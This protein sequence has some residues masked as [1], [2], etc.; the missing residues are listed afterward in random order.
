MLWAGLSSGET[1][2]GRRGEWLP[3]PLKVSILVPGR[4]HAFELAR[5]LINLGV[6]VRLVTSYPRGK[7][8]AWG[9]PDERVRS[10]FWHYLLTRLAWEMGGES[11]D[12]PLGRWHSRMFS[13]AASRQA[14]PAD[15]IHA[16]AGSA[17]DSLMRRFPSGRP[18][19][20]DRGS[21]HRIRQDEILGREHRDLGLFWPRRHPAM[22]RRELGEYQRATKITVPS[23]FVFRSFTE[24]GI[25]PGRLHLNGYGVDL[26][27]FVPME[28]QEAERQP[29]R[30]IH[31]GS[32]SVRKG[33]HHLCRGFRKAGLSGAQ[34]LLVGGKTAETDG[35]IGRDRRGIRLVGHLPQA[36]L[37]KEYQ[38]ASLFCLASL[39]EG[40]AMVQL[41]ALACGLPLVC[42]AHTGGE[43][44]LRQGGSG[45]PVGHGITEFPAGF[46]VPPADSS[47]VARV[48][49]RFDADRA[50]LAK[51]RRAAAELRA[52]DFSWRAYASRALS[53][54]HEV[55]K[56]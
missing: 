14:E 40:Q 21:A 48:L 54:Y 4:W 26:G 51:K 15:V 24:Q 38:K 41:Q 47:A 34:L 27:Q 43:D 46:V 12:I 49:R 16:W 32:L 42:T 8:R 18:V 28:S 13:L 11:V 30:I 22:V 44:L 55:L 52:L 53:L 7:T 17:W 45:Q 25:D 9:L 6:D 31:A 2:A 3:L 36:K 1:R 37:V 50:L 35:L 33:L 29:L 56:N 20:L 10:L 5:E 39:E 23:L 19:V